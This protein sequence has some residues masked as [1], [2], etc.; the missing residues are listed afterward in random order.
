MADQQANTVHG[1]PSPDGQTS[2][3]DLGITKR[4]KDEMEGNDISTC[5]GIFSFKYVFQ[6]MYSKN[7]HDMKTRAI[8]DD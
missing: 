3:F 5:G 1:Q 7:K 4:W 8:S 6:T 2:L